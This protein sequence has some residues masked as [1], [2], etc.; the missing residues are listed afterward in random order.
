MSTPLTF[1]KHPSRRRSVLTLAC[2][3]VVVAMGCSV[4]F[5]NRAV[6][7]TTPVQTIPQQLKWVTGF[8]LSTAYP[9]PARTWQGVDIFH[10]VDIRR[11]GGYQGTPTLEL[12][13]GPPGLRIYN[14]P[15]RTPSSTVDFFI[16]S[17]KS[18]PAGWYQTRL[19]GTSGGYSS[20][21]KFPVRVGVPGEHSIALVDG[22]SVTAPGQVADLVFQV[23]PN[24]GAPIP[25]VDISLGSL[26][27]GSTYVQAQSG[28]RVWVRV[29]IPASSASSSTY[30]VSVHS[31]S[32]AS[33]A[34]TSFILW[35]L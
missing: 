17:E 5:D 10:F 30:L 8:A 18:T 23:T 35:V 21:I 7:Q 3:V 19:R 6:A 24:A 15:N 28:D 4:G 27:A 34:Q 9:P 2:F 33:E 32:G 29:S 12:L 22:S 26:P 25:D 31:H 20:T 16:E 14:L 11:F 1:R 13:D